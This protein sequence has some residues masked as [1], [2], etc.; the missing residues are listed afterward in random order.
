MNN[1]KF[2]RESRYSSRVIVYLQK[3]VNV[4]ICFIDKRWGIYFT[5]DLNNGE[6]GFQTRPKSEQNPNLRIGWDIWHGK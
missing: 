1:V 5:C 3:A 6:M 2:L 4:M